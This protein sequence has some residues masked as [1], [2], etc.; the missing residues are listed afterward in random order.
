MKV[1]AA[2]V[3][4]AHYA[5][6]LD[7]PDGYGAAFCL[8]AFVKALSPAGSQTVDRF[9]K[10]CSLLRF[11]DS[12]EP[13][14]LGELLPSLESLAQLLED[15]AKPEILTDLKQLLA[16]IR[17]HRDIPIAGFES[18]IVKHVASASK[19]QSK[20]GVTP[21]D[22]PLVDDYLARLEAS[23]GDDAAFRA[24][25]REIETDRR[26]TKVEAV[27]LATR[28][29]G[30]TPPSTSR[31]KALQRVLHRHQKL[32]DFKRSSES[33]RRGRSAA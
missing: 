27:E 14:L 1:A 10:S 13:P 11:P 23:L 6:A 31:P 3:A 9:A 21:M 26:V 8:R 29:L 16:V 4:L 24:L 20:K 32:M 25:F 30:P 2:I 18:A 7:L 17:D 19:G 15:I 22:Q 12:R 28:F 33:I 5:D